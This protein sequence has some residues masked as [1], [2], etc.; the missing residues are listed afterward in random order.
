MTPEEKILWERIRGK[1]IDGIRF[2]RQYSVC[3]FILDFYSPELRL[4]IEVDGGYHLKE[5]QKAYDVAR[6]KVIES[7]QISFLRFTNDEVREVLARVIQD[8]KAKV[9]DLTLPLSKGEIVNEK[10]YINVKAKRG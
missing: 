9:N 7:F 10:S 5:S 3:G 6:Q 8:I 4:A 1:K 2:R